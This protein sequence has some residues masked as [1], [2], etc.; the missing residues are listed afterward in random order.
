[1]K[2][3]APSFVTRAFS[4]V[5]LLVVI[6]VIAIIA[7]FAVPAVTTMIRGSQLSQGSQ[8]VLDQMSL[9]RQTALA[10]NRPM[11]VRFYKFADPETP[12]ETPNRP[13][14]GFFRAIQ[15]FEVLDNGAAVPLGPI[16]RLPINVIMNEK[17]L[18]TLLNK[19]ERARV[20]TPLDSDP[21]M[22]DTQVKK[23]YHYTALRFQ[24]DGSTDLPITGATGAE[25]SGAT[26]GDPWYLTLHGTNVKKG[27]GETDGETSVL[28]ANYFTLQIDPVTGTVRSYRPNVGN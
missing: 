24:P 1:M 10:R 11:D 3:K 8:M 14:T 16:Q 5:E 7:G 18:S 15:V 6:S 23:N 21:E 9:A 12:G 2:T 22:P 4:L 19:G 20:T 13:E 25:G 17:G 26:K 27:A 28:P